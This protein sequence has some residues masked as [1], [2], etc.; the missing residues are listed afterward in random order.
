[1]VISVSASF[2]ETRG[3]EGGQPTEREGE[4]EE[5]GERTV[6]VSLAESEK[7]GKG[8]EKEETFAVKVGFFV[9][10]KI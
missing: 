2:L 6:S 5:G 1:M 8:G 7:E 10:N 9:F 3:A 4:G